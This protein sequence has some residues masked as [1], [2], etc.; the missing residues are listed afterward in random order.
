MSVP[1]GYTVHNS[2]DLGGRIA[3]TTGS[4]AMYSTLVNLQSGPRVLGES[5]E[6]RAL[7]GNKHALVDSLTAVSSGFGGDPNLITR[8]NAY[9]GKD[10]EFSG[11]FRRDRSYFDYDLLANPNIPGGQSIPIGPSAAPAGQFAWPQ[12]L[13]SPVLFNTV[14][15]M[16]DTSL[17]LLPLSKLTFRIGYS[18]NV[19]EGPTLRP[20]FSMTTSE[21]ASNEEALLEEYMRQS[22]DD[23]TGAVEWKPLQQT[24]VTFEERVT[25]IKADTSFTLAPS[26]LILQEPNGMRVAIGNYYSQ[27][28]GISCNKSSMMNP[29]AILYPAQTPGGLPI[30]DPACDVISSYYRSQPTRFLYPTEI[31]RFQSSSIRSLAMTGDVR[32]TKA[33][34]S[35]PNYYENFNGLAGAIRSIV[36]TGAATANREVFSVDYGV[37]WN[38]AKSFSL[39][40]QVNYNNQHQPGNLNF[41]GGATLSTPTTA[42]NETINYSGPLT[43]GTGNGINGTSVGANPGFLGQKFL[44]NNLVLSW[45]AT[46]RAVFTLGWRHTEHDVVYGVSTPSAPATTV[47]IN[48]NTAV[49]SAALRP[50]ANWSVNGSIEGGYADNAITPVGPRQIRRYKIRSLYRP[51]PWATISGAYNDL[52]RHNNTNNIADNTW[53]GLPL[54]HVDHSRVFGIGAALA[55]KEHYEFD[56]SYAYS[57]VYTATNICYTSGATA[58]LPGTATLTGTGAPNLC[59]QSVRGASPTQYEWYARDFMDAPT[60]FASAALSLSPV[61]T[62][63]AN[64]GYRISAV[65][66]SRFFN[67]ARDVNGS[68]NSTYQSPYVNLA[69]TFHKAWT[70]KARYDL[71]GYGEGGPSGPQYCSYASTSATDPATQPVPCASL[72]YPTGLTESSAGLTA[73]RNFHSNNVTLSVHYEF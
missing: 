39:S 9:K 59:P 45:D 47:D 1:A 67:D 15:R 6:L 65:S 58:T 60:Q 46:S 36:Y 3:G 55:P 10:W 68:L 64:L 27:T 48:E 72:P 32:Y 21:A 63:H 62:F 56:L 31:L 14:R 71:Y 18:Q 26:S 61:K 5:F 66:G 52:E 34:M 69:W 57:D 16:T 37:V 19:F 49:F 30:I 4:T 73:P 8:L 42:G 54:D 41:N 50:A 38:V 13:Q 11:L 44:V 20:D 17:T 7:P 51:R 35:L 43:P 23:W 40:E 2:V 12:V 25:H 28:P 22:S 29:T 70:W 53:T 33:N 24:R